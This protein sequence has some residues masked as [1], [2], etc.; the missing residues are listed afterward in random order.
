MATIACVRRAVKGTSQDHALLLAAPS[1]LTAE[2]AMNLLSSA[3]IPSLVHPDDTGSPHG[4]AAATRLVSSVRPDLY[5]PKHEHVRARAL[6][7][8]AWGE[9]R[10]RS[11][12]PREAS[13][14]EHR[15]MR[16][17]SILALLLFAALIAVACLFFS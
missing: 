9:A 8:E 13:R 14:S 5:V 16:R 2:L 7:T 4:R 12:E 1:R 11:L 10:L 15:G 6:L 17:Q 3:G